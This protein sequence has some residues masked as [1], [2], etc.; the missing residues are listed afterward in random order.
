MSEVGDGQGQDYA[1]E[2][3]AEDGT[4]RLLGSQ[5][6]SALRTSTCRPAASSADAMRA[7]AGAGALGDP[8]ELP[9]AAASVVAAPLLWGLGPSKF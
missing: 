3:A 9:S 2:E 8:W 1:A 5:G 7:S 4:C 6:V